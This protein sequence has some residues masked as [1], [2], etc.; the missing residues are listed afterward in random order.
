[1]IF[2][3]SKSEL[4]GYREQVGTN[5]VLLTKLIFQRVPVGSG[6]FS[7]ARVEPKAPASAAPAL[8]ASQSLML[9][10][11]ICAGISSQRSW[12]SSLLCRLQYGNDPPGRQLS[13][14]SVPIHLEMKVLRLPV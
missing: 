12:S 2:A 4:C 5:G 9:E 3:T 7:S 10:V 6:P 14:T 8:P 13:P 1:M 11:N